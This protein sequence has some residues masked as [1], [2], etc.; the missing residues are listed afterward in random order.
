MI[1]ASAPELL[2]ALTPGCLALGA[3]LLMMTVLR[4]EWWPARLGMAAI[5]VLLMLYYLSWR[6]TATLP[7]HGNLLDFSVGVVFLFGEALTVISAILSLFFLM[8][9]RNRTP[10]VEANLPHLAAMPQPPLIDVLIC[11]YN[12]EEQILERTI[13]GATGMTYRNY[14][15][16]VLDDSRRDW[17]RNLCAKL[18]VGYITRPD[19]THAK[20]GNINHALDRLAELP[21]PPDF[22]S[23]LDADFVPR[24]A[25]LTRAVS[26][27]SDPT[28]GIVQTPQHFINPDPIQANLIAAQ[29]W[30]DEQRFFFDMVLA[31][32]DAWDAAFC[33][34]TSSVIRFPALRAIGGFPTDS[35]TEDYLL[36]LRL[37]EIGYI[38]AYLNEPLTLGL[39]PEGIKEYLTQRGRWCLGFMQIARGRSGPLS[40][41]TNLPFIMRLS[42]I[43][44]FLGWAAV[45]PTRTMGLIIP[46]L[47]LLFGIKAVDANLFDVAHYFLPYYI[48]NLLALSWLTR[49][50]IIPIMSDVCQFVGGP[51]IIKAVFTGLAQP[52][53]QKF[54]VTAKGG[55]RTNGFVE[56]SIIEFYGSI[57]FLN[58]VAIAWAF[59]WQVRG[60]SIGFGTLALIWSWYNIMVMTIICFVAIEQPRRRRAERFVTSEPMLVSAGDATQ[61]IRLVDISISGA[62]CRGPAPAALGDTIRCR[63]GREE[64]AATIVRVRDEGF[65]IDFENT[66]AARAAL[67]RFFYAGDYVR[68]MESIAAADVGRTIMRRLM[69]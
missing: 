41:H 7:T 52:K 29:V 37:R 36:T 24:P 22:V 16:W 12:E 38:T 67:I 40:R 9:S 19:N 57:L 42:L 17:L 27:M 1:R 63:I 58:I 68:P 5:S 14:R 44:S 55:D 45:Y 28:I 61:P 10:D 53:R 69:R 26:L 49:G 50:R 32:R 39:A 64:V 51:A 6:L 48:W 31:S 46:I 60:D 3:V 65:A 54:K 15:V 34:G 4:R 56:W 18:G 66:P 43:E 2:T 59:H 8:R 47:Y 20:A 21:E 13:V 30:P 62:G 23:I 11:T 35:V 33:C 25:F